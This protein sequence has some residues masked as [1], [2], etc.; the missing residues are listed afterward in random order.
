VQSWP[1]VVIFPPLGSAKMC[2]QCLSPNQVAIPSAN[3]HNGQTMSRGTRSVASPRVVNVE[4][5]HQ[6]ARNRLPPVVF[7][8]LDGGAEGEVTLRANRSAFDSVTFRPRHAVALP[9]QCDLSVRVLDQNLSFPAILAPVGYS[10][11]M[12]PDGEMGA[13]KAAG[14]AG[15]AYILSTI[16]GHSLENVKAATPGPAWY[17]LYLLG[18][19]DAANAAIERARIAG[20]SA[21]VVTIDTAVAGMREKDFRNGMKELMGGSLLSKIPFLPQVFSHPQWLVSFLLDGGIPRLPNVVIPGQ[22]PMPLI[23]VAAA[24]ARAAV[25]WNDLRWIQETWRG[26]IVVKGVLTAE[27]AQLAVDHGAAG[28]VVSNHGGR[29]LDGVPATLKVLPEIVN[30]VGGRTE[31]LIDGG[32]RRGADIVKAI[33]LGARGVLIGRAYAYGLAAAGYDG[34]A[35]AL[36]ILRTDVERTLRL[37][38]CASITEL[39]RSYVE[40]SS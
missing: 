17:Q 33:C 32:I 37:L 3:A 15:T 29:Q 22:G 30:A 5:L 6:L 7:D 19:R 38:G 21:L 23:D 11:L 36:D 24:L 14:A 4:D 26:P 40:V 1:G 13:A 9:A 34:V 28:I 27:D 31:I 39:D 18:G 12:H 35:R 16:S 25:T 20:F 8:Y 2:R 10:R